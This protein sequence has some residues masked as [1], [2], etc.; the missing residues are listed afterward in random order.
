MRLGKKSSAS[1]SQRHSTLH[2]RKAAATAAMHGE[3][4]SGPKRNL[5]QHI[6]KVLTLTQILGLGIALT[7]TLVTLTLTLPT[8]T[9]TLCFAHGCFT[10][11]ATAHASE[12]KTS[13]F[14]A[15]PD[16]ATE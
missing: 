9:L 12:L 6:A 1:H 2:K 14:D 4:P 3:Q 11:H 15:T 5:T 13:P 7:L 8:L 16:G 10:A